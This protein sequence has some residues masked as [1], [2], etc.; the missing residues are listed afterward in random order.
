MK[1]EKRKTGDLGEAI[2]ITFMEKKGFSLVEQN[3]LQVFG[4]IDLVMKK[5]SEL[6][7]IE[8]KTGKLGSTWDPEQNLTM[9]KLKKFEKTV[10]HY[11]AEKKLE[12][13]TNRFGIKNS[14]V[15]HLWAVVVYLDEEDKKA[16]VKLI[17]ELY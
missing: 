1:T 9:D 14:L 3:Y 7:F 16:K 15:Y 4:E 8:V 6:F 12:T 2:A 10:E 17:E 13:I 5:D 11:I